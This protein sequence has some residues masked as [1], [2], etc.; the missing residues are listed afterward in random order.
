MYVAVPALVKTVGG[1]DGGIRT[2]EYQ[3]HNLA[4]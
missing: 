3:G 4:P 2:R 1:V